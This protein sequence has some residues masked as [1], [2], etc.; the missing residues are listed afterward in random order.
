MD[1][2]RRTRTLYPSGSAIPV[3]Q[4][5]CPE[6]CCVNVSARVAEHKRR[7]FAQRNRAIEVDVVKAAPPAY[8]DIAPNHV[9]EANAKGVTAGPAGRIGSQSRRRSKGIRL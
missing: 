4:V 6:H 8:H 3:E 5:A 7:P 1:C 9:I 2:R